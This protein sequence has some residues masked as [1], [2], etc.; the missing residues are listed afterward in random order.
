MPTK[1]AWWCAALALVAG[2]AG[3]IDADPDGPPG[4]CQT[5]LTRTPL[6]PEAGDEVVVRA[7]LDAPG[8][9]DYGW[10][11][12]WEGAPIPVQTNAPQISFIAAPG[13]YEVRLDIS[14]P[15]SCP[16]EA[17][18]FNARAKNANE[19]TMPFR[20]SSPGLAPFVH[21]E[22]VYGGANF[23]LGA[24]TVPGGA[25]FKGQ[26]RSGTTGV[27]AYLRFAPPAEPELAVETF[28]DTNGDFTVTITG[29][30]HVLVI[31]T[32]PSLAPRRF[33]D[34]AGQNLSVDAGREVTGT[35]LGP[36][37]GSLA[38]AVVAVRAGIVPSTLATTTA[39][40]AFALRIDRTDS[41]HAFDVTPPN[42][43]GL[44]RLR[45]SLTQAFVLEQPVQ[46]R[47]AGP[48]PALR[49]LAG[50]L[51]R[52]GGAPIAAARVSFVSRVNDAGT[53]EQGDQAVPATGELRIAATTLASGALPSTRVP[54]RSMAVVVEL[55]DGSHAVTSVDLTAGAPS[56][57]DIL[58]AVPITTELRTADGAAIEGATL[59]AVPAGDL[60]L[61]G[62]TSTIRATS[63]PGG[64]VNMQ[65]AAGGRYDLY[66]RDPRLRRGALRFVRSVSPSTVAASYALSRGLI[67]TGRLVHNG[68]PV[69]GAAVQIFSGARTGELPIAE[70]VSE[71]NGRFT[72]VVPDPGTQP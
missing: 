37:G 66:I 2:C 41:S 34:L 63:G 38:G 39:G 48:A 11:V 30:Q 27:P 71:A 8:V 36:A 69:G 67:A 59:D 57:I 55:A 23:T 62:V 50:T 49:D 45:A 52:R 64:T 31:P 53:V 70:G 9:L 32:S 51:V 42:G 14:G 7:L 5:T 35:V 56:S 60:A 16:D 10:T 65:L 20:I 26:V 58:P 22:Q 28:A 68:T 33:V 72:L 1:H 13:V 12:T 24:L 47:Y 19:A 29:Q 61:A 43:S 18:E 17:M 4:A 54:A 21:T 6:I 44:P 40:G 3:G 46:V 15:G 25:V